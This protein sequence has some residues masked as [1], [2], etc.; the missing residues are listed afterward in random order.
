MGLI[1]NS[2]ACN[3]ETYNGKILHLNFG[4]KVIKK[5]FLN[6]RKKQE[7]FVYKIFV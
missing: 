1:R 2:L 7:T 6:C 4:G 5:I 3:W